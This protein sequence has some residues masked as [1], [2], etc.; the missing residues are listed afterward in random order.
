[1]TNEVLQAIRTR[2]VVRRMTAE[3]ID[4]EQLITVLN[5]ARWAPSGG[6]RRLHR[7]G[8]SSGPSRSACCAWSR[9]GCSSIPRQRW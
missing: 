2:R 8:P 6:N 5:A 3:P 1:M 9:P 7:F 4:R